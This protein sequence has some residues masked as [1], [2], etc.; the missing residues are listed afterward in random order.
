[1]L[2]ETIRANPAYCLFRN[3]YLGGIISLLIKTMVR[4]TSVL[5]TVAVFLSCTNSPTPKE[6]LLPFFVGTYTQKMG[7]VDGKASGIY[8]C[9]LNLTSGE[10]TLSDSITDIENPSFLTISPDGRTLCAVS[11]LGGTEDQP[12]GTV[13]SYLIE[14]NGHLKRVGEVSSM[15]VAPCHLS[16]DSTGKWL[17]VANYGTGNVCAY[18]V[19]AFGKLSAPV[20]NIQHPGTSPWAHMIIPSPDGSSVWAVDKGVDS[21]FQYR[22]LE[23]GRLDRLQSVGIGKGKGPRHIAFHPTHPELMAVIAELSSEVLLLKQDSSQHWKITDFVSS[24]PAGFEGDNSGADIHFH[25]NGRYLYASNRGHNSLVA[26]SVDPELGKAQVEG[27]ISVEGAIPRNFALTPDGQWLLV[28]NQNSGT[29][30]SF[31]VDG[32]TGRLLLTGKPT[33]IPTPVCIQFLEIKK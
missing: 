33:S 30:V 12:F 26:L 10:I 11:E 1:M 8:T 6:N 15:G 22:L 4:L 17:F 27:H 3:E 25:P 14:A 19:G 32:A 21:L 23:D 31:R 9:Y 5:F 18:S 13:V 29:I 28:A 7:H 16:M 2:K 20:S 24:L